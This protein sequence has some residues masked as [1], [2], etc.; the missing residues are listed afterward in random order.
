MLEACAAAD[1]ALS[2]AHHRYAAT[3]RLGM[4]G[5]QLQ[6]LRDLH[7]WHDLQRTAIARSEYERYIQ[8]TANRIRGAHPSVKVFI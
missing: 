8:L 2:G 1:A 7:E 5:L 4:T 6:S 3:G